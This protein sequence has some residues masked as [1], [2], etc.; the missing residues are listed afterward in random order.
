MWEVNLEYLPKSYAKI[1]YPGKKE[2]MNV[3]Y[4]SFPELKMFAFRSGFFIFIFF[5]SGGGRGGTPLF[6]LDKSIE[7][8]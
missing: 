5:W 7:L 6:S 4:E 2:V 8:N 3:F 1:I